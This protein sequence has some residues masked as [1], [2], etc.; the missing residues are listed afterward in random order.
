MRVKECRA[1]ESAG[2]M[3]TDCDRASPP[4]KCKGFPW[5]PVKH[6]IRFSGLPKPK[7]RIQVRVIVGHVIARNFHQQLISNLR[8]KN[9]QQRRSL[10]PKGA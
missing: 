1:R 6:V 2:Q 8:T 5:V 10:R 9:I 7:Q 3:M 4:L